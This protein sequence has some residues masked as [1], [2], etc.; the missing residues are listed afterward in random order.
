MGGDS[1]VEASRLIKRRESSLETTEDEQ[2]KLRI[3]QYGIH[4]GIWLY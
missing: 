2:K 3:Q 4:G 1:C